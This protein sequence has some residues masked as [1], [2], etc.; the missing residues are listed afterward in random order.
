MYT[1]PF[2]WWHSLDMKARITK[3]SV[4]TTVSFPEITPMALFLLYDN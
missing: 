1:S 3:G 4:Y 2:Y